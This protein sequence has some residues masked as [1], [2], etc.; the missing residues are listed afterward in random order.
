VWER[1]GSVQRVV[2]AALKLSDAAEESYG[3]AGWNRK[4]EPSEMQAVTQ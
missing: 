1:G 2:I 3:G 4:H